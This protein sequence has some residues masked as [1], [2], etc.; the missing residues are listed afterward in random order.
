GWSEQY[1]TLLIGYENGNLD[2]FAGGNIENM[3][4]IKSSPSYTGLK[5]INH[6][7]TEGKYAYICTNFGIV[8]YD[9]ARGIVEETFVIGP[10][11]VTLAVN[12]LAFSQDSIFAATELGLYAA[13]RNAPLL[14]FESWNPI[15]SIGTNI[16]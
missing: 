16:P 3:Q 8:Q 9:M 2:L 1:K 11:G 4:D 7:E 12:R 5:Q 13:N 6:I 10:N 15:T 14:T